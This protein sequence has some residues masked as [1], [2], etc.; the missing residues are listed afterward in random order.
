MPPL[1]AEPFIATSESAQT[2]SAALNFTRLLVTETGVTFPSSEPLPP[3]SSSDLHDVKNPPK[4][5]EP[6]ARSAASL[7][8]LLFFIISSICATKQW[9]SY[10]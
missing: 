9:H 1:E 4:S 5:S 10:A 7:P 3:P 8:I 2:V 6:A